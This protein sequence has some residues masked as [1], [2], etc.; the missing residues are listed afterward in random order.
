MDITWFYFYINWILYLHVLVLLA[1]YKRVC[2]LACNM[3][4]YT[5]I[6]LFTVSDDNGNRHLC[7]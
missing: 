5:P 3:L 4:S 1:M 7:V 6:F 2:M